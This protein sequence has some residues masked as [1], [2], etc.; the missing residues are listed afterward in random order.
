MQVSVETLAGLTRKLTIQVP[1]QQLKQAYDQRLQKLATTTKLKGFRPGKIP[2]RVIEQRYGQGVWQEVAGEVMQQSLYS[3]MNDKKLRPAGSPTVTSF[4]AE[5]NRPM[6][7]SSEIEILPEFELKSLRG[8]AVETV[9]AEVED[10]LIEKAIDN[11]RQQ[12]LDW[13]VVERGAKKDD[14]VIISFEGFKAGKSIEKSSIKEVA[15]VLGSGMMPADFEQALETCQAGDEKDITVTYPEQHQNKDIAGQEVS[16][17]VSVHRIEESHLPTLDEAFLNKIGIKGGEEEL[18]KEITASL[19]KEIEQMAKSIN[20][21]A[22]VDELLKLHQSIELPK[23]LLDAEIDSMKKNMSQQTKEVDDDELH[24]KT[25]KRVALGLI[26]G[27]YAN[28]YDIHID[29]ERVRNLVMSFAASCPKPDEL[30]QWYYADKSRLAPIEWMAFEEQ[31]AD[32]LL[33][34]A[35]IKEKRLSYDEL[36]KQVS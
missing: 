16:F 8:V 25:Q 30:V 5:F 35:E 22:V 32:K 3:A 7:F 12:H 11:L 9:N 31:V 19:Q 1:Q 27:E 6:E 23:S 10:V 17:K 29:P 18:K 15:I 28:K 14:R 26:I 20:K 33:E 13:Q 2:L 36:R 4:K 21:Q 34:Q 24:Q